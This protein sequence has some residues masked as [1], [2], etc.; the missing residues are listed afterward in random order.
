M[1]TDIRDLEPGAEIV[2]DIVI[3]GGGMAG[4]TLA[5]EWAGA[6]KTVAIL[7]SGGLEMD[8]ATQDLYEG[9]ATLSDGNGVERDIGD[10]P[11]T[12]RA[13]LY[14]G[15]S[16][17]WGGKCVPLDPADF[18]ARPWIRDSGW[19][20][21]RDDLQPYYDRACD[22][23]SIPHFDKDY[24]EPRHEGRPPLDING[25]VH[26]ASLP[27]TYTKVTSYAD[28][29][30]FDEFLYGFTDAANI[31]VYLHANA[32]DCR[33]SPD[34][35]RLE[36]I[37]IASLDG[38]RYVA[39]GAVYV[40]ACGGIENARL[41]MAANAL[42][43][44]RFGA[45]SDA[46]GRYFQ[47]HTV[48]LKNRD[49]GRAA[50]RVYFSDPPGPLSLY[51]DRGV[52]EAPHAV[53]GTTL[54]GQARYHCG[55]F[56][57]T[58]D[59]TEKGADAED[60]ALQTLAA[61]LDGA[62]TA[63]R[64]TDRAD[65]DCSCYFMTENMPNPM[66]RVTL[67][68]EVDALGLPRIHLHWEYGAADLEGFERSV[69]GFARELGAAHAGRVACPIGRDDAVSAMLPSRHHMGTTRM[70]A[71]PATGIVDADLKC[72]DAEN[73]YITGSSVFPTSGIANPTLT[74]LALTIRL[75]DHL[76][77]KLGAAA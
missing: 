29:P 56:T 60:R 35:A 13:R 54:A 64:A 11:V 32:I 46:L 33:F 42:N 20:V 24:A 12:S 52:D 43:G 68:D 51:V 55:A 50:T 71:D 70:H 15:S 34:G 53:L 17:W 5:R 9:T 45:R 58:M 75:A 22:L 77:E 47:G 27:R 74:I 59:V 49:D 36:G 72:H 3:I 38:K 67:G 8:E 26:V 62:D 66:S 16:H 19:P 40:L 25:S 48:I 6:E 41:L 28:T 39:R 44:A 7:E 2:A 4:I 37:G 63:A 76:K 31:S 65:A 69:D 1:I 18:A 57:V 73:L 30:H 14:G 61:R 21:S 10:Y 23:L